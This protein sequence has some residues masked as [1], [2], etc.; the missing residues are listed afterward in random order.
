LLALEATTKVAAFAPTD[1]GLNPTV[2]LQVAFTAK[3]PTQAL[4]C[5]NSLAFAPPSE[6]LLIVSA[7]WPLFLIAIACVV[8]LVLMVVAEKAALVGVEVIEGTAVAT[9]VPL[10]AIASAGELLA[11]EFTVIVA[12][13]VPTAVGV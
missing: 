1:I 2:T 5:V 4:V 13:R 9:A 12:V 10:V 11:S 6:I 3:E 8:A 7:A